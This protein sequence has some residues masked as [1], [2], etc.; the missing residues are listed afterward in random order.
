MHLALTVGASVALVAAGLVLRYLPGKGEAE[1]AVM[2]G[3]PEHR[4]LA[5]EPEAV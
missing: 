1:T 4:A 5:M 3:A 2:A